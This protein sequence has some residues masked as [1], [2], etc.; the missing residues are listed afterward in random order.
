MDSNKKKCPYCGE[1]IMADA[2][3]FRHCGEWLDKTT[4]DNVEQ[5]TATKKEAP[6]SKKIT[7][8]IAGG[9]VIILAV[10]VGILILSIEKSGS[11]NTANN[12]SAPVQ[13]NVSGIPRERQIADYLIT[14]MKN[15]GY[16]I[17]SD[18]SFTEISNISG[19]DA[20]SFSIIKGALTIYFENRTVI[21][22]LNDCIHG[23][24]EELIFS[25]VEEFL[26]AE[27]QWNAKIES[28]EKENNEI[29]QLINSLMPD[30]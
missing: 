7:W 12:N 10:V 16:A 17:S 2:K 18:A 20:K 3:K 24:N 19:I 28:L 9:V 6:K 21:D 27:K 14:L 15:K 25:S 5:P 4:I 11:D 26:E 13:E 1:E 29:T 30:K 23:E 8:I 22:H